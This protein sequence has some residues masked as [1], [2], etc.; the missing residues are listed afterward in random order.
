[1][2][3]PVQ[4][5]LREDIIPFID[6]TNETLPMQVHLHQ[7]PIFDE[8]F[9]KLYFTPVGFFNANIARMAGLSHYINAASI[10]S[11]SDNDPL[12]QV[13]HSKPLDR[14]A[15]DYLYLR[16][17]AISLNK[18]ESHEL[19]KPGLR[20]LFKTAMI[21]D[22]ESP[23][24]V[25]AHYDRAGTRLTENNKDEKDILY[26][27]LRSTHA[28]TLITPYI[29]EVRSN[30]Y[31]DRLPRGTQRGVAIKIS[32]ALPDL[33]TAYAELLALNIEE[34]DTLVAYNKQLPQT[35]SSAVIR[36]HVSGNMIA[37]IR[38]VTNDNVDPQY[39]DAGIY[40][41]FASPA[42]RYLTQSLVPEIAAIDQSLEQPKLLLGKRNDERSDIVITRMYFDLQRKL[43]STD[44]PQN[45]KRLK[46]PPPG[47]DLAAGQ[48]PS[49]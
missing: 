8:A 27:A 11:S 16:N 3:Q 45:L 41:H 12:V 29:V 14:T 36:S 2:E 34:L 19:L 5:T 40:L 30:V 13:E 44:G 25:L 39:P 35:T 9:I 31:R 24:M 18:G 7:F 10:Y 17:S 22:L 6:K 32:T 47:N 23:G 46:R 38:N 43:S 21:T 37:E 49:M 48:K 4:Y 42:T 1:M 33:R 28:N 26:A 20:Q 15:A